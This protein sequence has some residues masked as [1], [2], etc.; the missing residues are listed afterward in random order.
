[1]QSLLRAGFADSA[2]LEKISFSLTDGSWS[3]AEGEEALGGNP[4]VLGISGWPGLHGPGAWS[5]QPVVLLSSGQ[6]TSELVPSGPG[7]NL[8]CPYGSRD[9]KHQMKA[10]LSILRLTTRGGIPLPRGC[11]RLPRAGSLDLSF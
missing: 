11:R 4:S 2:G 10:A 9:G 1:M 5:L 6:R 7:G 8:P 3:Q